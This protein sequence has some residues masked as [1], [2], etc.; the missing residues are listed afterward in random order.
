MCRVAGPCVCRQENREASPALWQ[1]A[2]FIR[3]E[4]VHTAAR[5]IPSILKNDK[6]EFIGSRFMCSAGR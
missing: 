4:A 5:E 3:I 1:R 6:A 2:G